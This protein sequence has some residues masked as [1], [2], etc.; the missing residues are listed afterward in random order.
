MEL[1][2]T[3][4]ETLRDVTIERLREDIITG[5]LAP[6]E[7]IRDG[8]LAER[9]AVSTSPLREALSVLS[10]EWLIIMPPKQAKRVAPIDRRTSLDIFELH[11]VLVANTFSYGALQLTGEVLRQMDESRAEL[12]RALI[13]GDQRSTLEAM[14]GF[15]DPIHIAAPNRAI[16]KVLNNCYPWMI[17]LYIL[18]IPSAQTK[19]GA[20]ADEVYTALVEGNHTVASKHINSYLDETKAQIEERLIV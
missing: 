19:W 1:R 7:I 11:R 8:E 20:L 17:R 10:Q 4:T 9:Y 16:R 5:V 3:K 15:L 14:K 18:V 2:K 6:G 13:E 12:H